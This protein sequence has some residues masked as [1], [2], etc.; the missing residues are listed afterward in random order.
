MQDFFEPPLPMGWQWISSWNIDRSAFVDSDGWAYGPGFQNLNWP[1][2]TQKLSSKS[3]VDVVRRRRWIRKR[4]KLAEEVDSS[5]K[6]FLVTV[7]PGSSCVLPWKCVLSGSE[8]CLKV[9]PSAD[10]QPA[11]P[12]GQTVA[13]GSPDAFGKDQ[14]VMESQLLR[15]NTMKQGNKFTDYI[16]KLDHLEKK[17][18]LVCCSPKSEIEQ[19]WLSTGSDASVLHSALNQPIYDWKISF[20]SPLRLENRLPCPAEFTIWE[21]AKDGGIQRQHGIIPSRKSVHVYSADVRKSVYLT[22]FVHGGWILEKVCF[23]F[24]LHISLRCVFCASMH[25]LVSFRIP[26]SFWIS[27]LMITSRHSGWSIS[28]INGESHLS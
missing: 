28:K 18:I 21:K 4:Q 17:D 24:A 13:T 9:R 14:F 5:S 12:W 15:Q 23:I 7:D 25:A 22:L 2:N 19:F 8:Q 3:A 20:N 6:T 26:F 11:F 1:P 27:C 16:F 10:L